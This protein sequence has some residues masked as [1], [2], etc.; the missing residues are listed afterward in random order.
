MNNNLYSKKFL[1]IQFSL[2]IN[3]FIQYQIMGLLFL[4]IFIPVGV[5][6]K[7][8]KRDLLGLNFYTSNN[9][10]WNKKQKFNPKNM[11]YQF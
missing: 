8:K 1:W 10:Y 5:I 9:S 4:F 11:K 2:I 7:Y 6:F 3:K